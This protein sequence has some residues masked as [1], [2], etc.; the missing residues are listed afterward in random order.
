MLPNILYDFENTNF[1]IYIF[2]DFAVF[3]IWIFHRYPVKSQLSLIYLEKRNAL[4]DLLKMAK[5]PW[6]LFVSFKLNCLPLYFICLERTDAG[7]QSVYLL[8][9]SERFL[10]LVLQR[11]PMKLS[12]LWELVQIKLN[13]IVLFQV[14]VHL[15]LFPLDGESMPNLEKPYICC[16]QTWSIKQLCQV[17]MEVFLHNVRGSLFK[18][19][20]TIF[21]VIFYAVCCC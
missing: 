10:L 3:S 19:I 20:L 14:D 15:S 11:E 17:I 16:K 6:H 4:H 12:L 9:D 7:G 13:W 2:G 18:I 8:N 5:S 1:A 21:V